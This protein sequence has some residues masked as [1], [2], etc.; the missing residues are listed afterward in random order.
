LLFC[1]LPFKI[2]PKGTKLKVNQVNSKEIN[3]MANRID[4]E[5]LKE[6]H[7]QGV[8]AVDIAKKMCVSQA[9]VC[10]ML[11]KMGLALLLPHKCGAAHS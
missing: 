7:D 8:R 6:L 5:K 11:K 3:F 4:K 2:Y 1:R 10:K 9:A